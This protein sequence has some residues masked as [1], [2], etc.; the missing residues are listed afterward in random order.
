[1]KTKTE[2]QD[3]KELSDDELQMVSGGR[4]TSD[5]YSPAGQSTEPDGSRMFAYDKASYNLLGN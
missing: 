1:M 2:L 4:I 3:L 5:D